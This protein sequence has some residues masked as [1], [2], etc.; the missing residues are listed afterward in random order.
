MPC[1]VFTKSLITVLALACWHQ[2]TMVATADNKK[3]RF[4]QK[5]KIVEEYEK[6][7]PKDTIGAQKTTAVV[8]PHKGVPALWINDKPVFPMAMIPIGVFPKDVCRDFAAAGVHIYSHIIW[9]SRSGLTG[10]AVLAKPSEIH[11]WLGPGQYAFERL[12]R[13]IQTIIAADPQAYIFLRVKLNPPAWWRKANPDELTHYEDG[14]RG[15][16]YS[17]ASEVWEKTYERMLRDLIRHIESSSYAGHIIGYQP[18]GG[19]ASEW[20]WWG[21]RKGMIDYSPAARNRFRKWLN[22]RYHGDV[23][24]LR[25]SW[26]DLD[27]TFETA[28]PPSGKARKQSEYLLFRDPRQAG[29]VMDF[30]RF[31]GDV[32]THNIVKSCRICK[33]ET[34]G[35][36]IVGVFYGYSLYTCTGPNELWNC[37]YLGL[38]KVLDCPH[39]DFLCSPTDYAKRRG[40]TP[41][42]FV[43]AYTASYILHNKLY[44]DEA[45]VRTC[46][47]TS[48]EPWANR[49]LSETLSV[50]ERGFGYMLTKGT[51]LW[52]FT[53]T[54]DDTFHQD[55]MM[56]DIAKMQKIGENN[57]SVD[58]KPIH[59]VAVLADEESYYRMRMGV[60]ELTQPLIRDMQ[61]KLATMGA[62]YDMY[63]LSDI[64]NEKMPDYKLYIFLNP[65]YVS[66][67]MRDAIKKK[68]RRNGAVSAWFYATGFIKE[69]GTFSEEAICDLTGIR[70]RHK[71]EK[72]GQRLKITNFDHRITSDVSPSDRLGPTGELGPMFWV[73]DPEAVV[74]GH[75]VPDGPVGIAARDF[76]AWR[77]VYCAAPGMSTA[78]LRGLIQYAG[79]HVYSTSD[80][81][82]YA[83]NNY[84][85]I[86]TAKAGKKHIAL[87]GPRDVYDVLQA[88]LVGRNLATIDVDLPAGVTRIYQ[89][90]DTKKHVVSP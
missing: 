21:F 79:G 61:L 15:P 20:Y 22:E 47:C 76:G 44:W 3:N 60:K 75:L 59:D 46:L 55:E 18:A 7:I 34:G 5:L 69:D 71:A 70:V 10:G 23:Q 24:L 11:W 1:R 63:L 78:V 66:D 31:L 30:Q 29:H 17:M 49:S 58:K 14:S 84:L 64:A 67:T 83:N 89:L 90:Q 82:F 6:N 52:W 32:T 35:K 2:G 62:P 45:D 28:E 13:Q 4:E 73:E 42:N 51:A 12:D 68:V 27:V 16:Q 87:P 8:K 81:T 57:M 33:E 85:M 19:S 80:D 65:F 72:G 77:S 36:K 86:H 39:V 40:G 38:R 48:R 74:L 54:G 9:S 41:G 53:L 25:K 43:S 88:K 56:E 37:G 50:F 26:N